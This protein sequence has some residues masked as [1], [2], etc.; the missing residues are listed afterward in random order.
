MHVDVRFDIRL[1]EGHDKVN[2]LDMPIVD[3]SEG[4]DKTDSLPRHDGRIR[5]PIINKLDGKM[6]TSAETR[7]PLISPMG[8]RFRFIDQT[9]GRRFFCGGTF[10]TGT[11]FK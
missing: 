11:T 3:D 2:R 4:E 8:L 6:T 1:R 10:S 7:L 9:I 5:I